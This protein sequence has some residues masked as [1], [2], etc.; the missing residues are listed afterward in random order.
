MAQ[1]YSQTGDTVIFLPPGLFWMKNHEWNAHRRTAM[2]LS[3][4]PGYGGG[5][6]PAGRGEGGWQGGR[7][8]SSS[9]YSSLIASI[10]R[11]GK[12]ITTCS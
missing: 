8:L 11:E 4:T 1:T 6:R 10:S 3:T 9:I 12:E 2:S 5:P 7:R